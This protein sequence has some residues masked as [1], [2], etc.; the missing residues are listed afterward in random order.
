MSGY[1]VQIGLVGVLVLINAAFAGSELALVSLRE[2]QLRRLERES[3]RGAV[4]ATLARDPNRFLATIQI[5]I[6]LAGFLASASAAVA[7]A[8][9]LEGPLEP[10]GSAARPVSIVAITVVLAYVTLVVGELAPK[11][12]AMQRAERWGLVVARPLSAIAKASRPVVWLL[13]HSTDLVVRLLG[14]D[15]TREREEVT[16]EEL[17]D[18]VASQLSFSDQQRMIIAGAFEVADRTLQEILHPRPDVLTLDANHACVDGL[19][20]LSGSGYSRAPVGVGGVLDDVVG[21]VHLRDLLA[22]GDALIAAVAKPALFLPE[23]VRALD[24]LHEMQNARA[25]LA[26]VV[27]EHGGAEGIVTVEDIVEE[28]VGEIYDESDRDVQTVRTG[29][30]GAVVVPGRFPIHDLDD[31]G[32]DVPDGDY[33]TVAGLVLSELQRLPDRPG[34]VVEVGRWR[35]TVTRVGKRSITEVEIT[36][37]GV[38]VDPAT[39]G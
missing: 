19:A 34:D 17:R 14:A 31:V 25:Q 39:E 3:S 29:P 13:S 15:P 33:T 28:L 38:R 7:L 37:A 30:G 6:T 2:S 18:M 8:E 35:F 26:V 5:G 16:E 32:V 36:P 4:L 9:P 12:I 1:W 27:N 11:R 20:R 10:L 22:D 24:A 23:T 21:V